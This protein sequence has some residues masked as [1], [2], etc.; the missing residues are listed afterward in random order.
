M[1]KKPP[2]FIKKKISAVNT[3]DFFPLPAVQFKDLL[4]LKYVVKLSECRHK[5]EI[6][7]TRQE[8]IVKTGAFW[9]IRQNSV[10]K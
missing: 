1:Y 5:R 2:C 9:K 8:G 4:N 6:R 7:D 3:V 10:A